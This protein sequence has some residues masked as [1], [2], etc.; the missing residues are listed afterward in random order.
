MPCKVFL[1]NR[2][3]LRCSAR[4]HVASVCIAWR[5][6][7]KSPTRA[8]QN[9]TRWRNDTTTLG[10]L[11][12]DASLK[13]MLFLPGPAWQTVKALLNASSL[14]DQA[15]LTTGFISFPGKNLLARV[16]LQRMSFSCKRVL[17][18]NTEF[19]KSCWKK[20][21]KKKK[22]NSKR[23]CVY[24]VLC[25]YPLYFM[26][27]IRVPRVHL[28][29]LFK[30]YVLLF[31]ENKAIDICRHLSIFFKQ[32]SPCGIVSFCNVCIKFWVNKCRDKVYFIGRF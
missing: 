15:R 6:N 9:V 30:R 28:C 20:K 26:S 23:N 5:A 19:R 22:K 7:W 4:E 17:W 16:Y 12:S 1:R 8:R 31:G 2:V 10:V 24:W 11:W 29:S 25:V 32:Q 3:P 13:S 18:L 14:I 21:I 27:V